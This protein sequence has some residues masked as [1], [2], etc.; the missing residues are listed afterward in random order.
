M[1]VTC[2]GCRTTL[3]VRADLPPGKRIKCPKCARVFAPVAEIVEEVTEEPLDEEQDERPRRRRRQNRDDDNDEPE[4]DDDVDHDEDVERR[5]RRKRG[6]A[7]RRSSTALLW[8]ILG[9]V[10]ALV[11]IVA[12]VLVLMLARGGGG[13][14]GQHEEAM[15]ESL[16]LM[17]ELEAA[18][19]EVKDQNS[20]RVAAGKIEKVCDRVEALGKR[21]KA[22]PKLTPAED[23]QLQAKYKPQTDALTQRMQ[24]VGFQAGMNSGGEP[25]F[26]AAAKRLTR[27]GQ[28][29]K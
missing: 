16:Q 14:F 23:K 10:G 19:N 13:G 12:V 6:K 7:R 27:V 20:A 26:V 5:P 29:F 9:G 17:G 2:P 22:L 4:R 28:A 25:S 8:T 21:V 3:K 15:K 24:K 11:V 18:L 1:P